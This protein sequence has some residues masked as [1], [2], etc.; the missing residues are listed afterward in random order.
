MNRRRLLVLGAAGRTGRLV[1]DHAV[2]QGYQVTAFVHDP[3]ADLQR[4]AGVRL[5]AGDARRV[6]DLLAAAAGQHAVIAS[7]SGHGAVSSTVAVAWRWA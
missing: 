1:V 6:S 7:I 5:A 4:P 2:H 3:A